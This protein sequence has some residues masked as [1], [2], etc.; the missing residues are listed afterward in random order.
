MSD[1]EHEELRI[2]CEKYLMDQLKLRS[3][4][5]GRGIFQAVNS[6]VGCG[7]LGMG[8]NG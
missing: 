5:R 2:I 3:L 6:N 8:E 4:G 7:I 1:I